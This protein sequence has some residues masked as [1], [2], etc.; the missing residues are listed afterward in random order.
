M[1]SLLI[2][3]KDRKLSQQWGVWLTKRDPESALKVSMIISSAVEFDNDCVD[4]QLLTSKDNSR[5]R[6]KPEDD[7]VLLE[8]VREANPAAGVQFLEHLVLQKRS[9][10]I[11][12]LCIF[13][14]TL[15]AFFLAEP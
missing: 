9:T 4:Y 7:I 11:L 10:V 14:I 12:L 1:F 15:I 2:E 6:D 3:K 5:R 13:T 8:Q